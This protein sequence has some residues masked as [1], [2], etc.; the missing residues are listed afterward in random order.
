MEHVHSPKHIRMKLAS[1]LF[2]LDP[3]PTHKKHRERSWPHR[4]ATVERRTRSL[5]HVSGITVLYELHGE[6]PLM[7][8]EG[9]E[10]PPRGERDPVRGLPYSKRPARSVEY[11]IVEPEQGLV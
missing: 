9:D 10:T 6:W 5:A 3:W 1:S 4:A 11:A 2:P 7:K 8:G